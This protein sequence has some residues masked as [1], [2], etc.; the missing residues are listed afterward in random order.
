MSL[1]LTSVSDA[2]TSH[3]FAD[4]L[5]AHNPY[6]LNQLNTTRFVY[7]NGAIKIW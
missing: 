7:R 4:Q 6:E 5:L 1:L 3:D 2:H